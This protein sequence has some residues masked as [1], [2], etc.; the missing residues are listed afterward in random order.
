M[1]RLHLYSN[2]FRLVLAPIPEEEVYRVDQIREFEHISQAYKDWLAD[3][4]E[5]G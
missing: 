5:K 3:V 2:H 1:L 4:L